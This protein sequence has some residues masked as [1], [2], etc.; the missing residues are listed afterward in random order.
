MVSQEIGYSSVMM[1]EKYAKCNLRKL[2]DDFPLSRERIALRPTPPIEVLEV[3]YF[4]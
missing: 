3:S 1:M 4:T 2:Q